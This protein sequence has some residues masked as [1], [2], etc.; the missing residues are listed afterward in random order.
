MPVAWKRQWGKGR[1][2]YCA[3]GHTLDVLEQPSITTLLS[4]ALLWACRSPE[5]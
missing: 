3:L 4:R 1:V 2:F 5:K